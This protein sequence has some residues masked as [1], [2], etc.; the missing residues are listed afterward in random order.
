MYFTTHTK[1]ICY[2]MWHSYKSDSLFRYKIWMSKIALQYDVA[3][4]RGQSTKPEE[5]GATSD[6]I[7]ACEMQFC[8]IVP[9]EDWIECYYCILK[10]LCVLGA[11]RIIFIKL[12]RCFTKKK[13]LG[14]EKIYHRC[15]YAT[16]V[17][18]FTLLKRNLSI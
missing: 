5:W 13:T 14:K 6:F 18:I 2:A 16:S 11:H 15:Y 4:S 3:H 8:I 9:F 17:N 12:Q 1:N 7:N 10:K